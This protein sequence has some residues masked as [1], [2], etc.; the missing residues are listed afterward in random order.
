MN[1]PARE[2]IY[3]A[4][5]ARERGRFGGSTSGFSGRLPEGL[6]R[7]AR[8]E[9]PELLGTKLFDLTG[10]VALVTGA[11]RG[12]GRTMACALAAAGADVAVAARTTTETES[13]AD[14]ITGMGRRAEWL[15]LD[16]TSEQ[17]CEDA[18]A[19]TIDRLGRIDIL[20]NNA[21][22]NVRKPVLELELDEFERVLDTNLKGYFLC[23]KA[24]GRAMVAQGSGKMINISSI[25][26][27]VA[28]PNQTAYA[29]SKG[30]IEQMT[31]VMALE[32]AQAGVQVNAI[33]P[34]YFETELTRPLFDD[35]ERNE[36]ITGRT[37]MG[38]WGQPHEL[39]GAVIFLASQASDYVTGH[40]LAVDGG[41]LAW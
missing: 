5:T 28:L 7:I 8:M 22:I 21:G 10:R 15:M 31:K 40:T 11:G 26:G 2:G 13:L 33:A 29:T 4:A 41:W 9:R 17:S 1:V 35:P 32:W 38:R 18:V 20:V 25:M 37:P 16:V 36:F 14:E 27:Q 34:T 23:G 12:L 24:A 6:C 30:G 19:R 39:A 3:K